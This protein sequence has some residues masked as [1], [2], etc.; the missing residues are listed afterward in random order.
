[1]VEWKGKGEGEQV[2]GKDWRQVNVKRE[3]QRD[4]LRQRWVSGVR[5][6]HHGPQLLFSFFF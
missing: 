6:L 2:E 3:G 5:G 4:G 1:M